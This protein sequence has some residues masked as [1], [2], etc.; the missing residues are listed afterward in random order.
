MSN[1]SMNGRL[2]LGVGMIH[3]ILRESVEI[4]VLTESSASDVVSSLLAQEKE[5]SLKQPSSLTKLLA[6]SL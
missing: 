3:I 6:L 4:G 5:R 1:L 2:K